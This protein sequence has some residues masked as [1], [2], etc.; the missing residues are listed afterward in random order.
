MNLEL[1]VQSLSTNDGSLPDI[2]FS[3]ASSKGLV[4]A[5]EIIQ[6]H[7]SAI[8]GNSHYW[9][10]SKEIDIP[11]IYG[12]NYAQLFIAGETDGFHVL[13][14]GLHSNSKK[15]IPDI[16]LSI[17]NNYEFSLDYRMGKE[18]N[19][20]A[21]EGLFELISELESIESCKCISHSGNQFDQTENMLLKAYQFWKKR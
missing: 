19:L 12:N 8:D 3:C 13:F 18:W 17:Y 1:T 11:L 2:N 20:S 4:H 16:G 6:K 5:Y 15:A 14:I 7:A 9:S 10:L 21:V